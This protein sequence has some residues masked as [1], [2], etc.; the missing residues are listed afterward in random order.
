MLRRHFRAQF[1]QDANTGARDWDWSNRRETRQKPDLLTRKCRNTAKRP[2]HSRRHSRQTRMSNVHVTFYFL[3]SCSTL[4]FVINRV[5]GSLLRISTHRP[6]YSASETLVLINIQVV[7]SANRLNKPGER[8]TS[9][10]K[11]PSS[12]IC[13]SVEQARRTWTGYCLAAATN[14]ADCTSSNKWRILTEKWNVNEGSR[15]GFWGHS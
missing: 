8:N 2:L 1:S 9:P 7:T 13:E 3:R 11:Y 4:P 6:V 10:D 5:R 14:I 12:D 15:A